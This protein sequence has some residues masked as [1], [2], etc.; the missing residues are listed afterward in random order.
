MNSLNQSDIFER[1]IILPPGERLSWVAEACGRDTALRTQVESLLRAHDEARSFMESTASDLKAAKPASESGGIE[2][3]GDRIGRYKL[4]QKIGEGGCGVVYMAE[5]EESV[6]RRVAIKIIKPGMDTKAV[7]ARFSAEREAL[8]R[9]EHPNI[10][11]VYDAGATLSGRPYFVMEL[12]RGLRIT[13][14]CDQNNFSTEQR[15]GLFNKVCEAIHHAHQ[16][17]I[18]H[19]DIKPSNIL[20]TLYDGQPVPKVIDFGIA[21]AMHGRLTDATLFTAFEQFIGTPAYVSPEQA[22]MS[23][24]DIDHRSDI[25][26][27]GVLLY[28][29]LMGRTPFD[30]NELLRSGLDE[31]RRRIREQEP[32]RPSLRLRT[33]NDSDRTTVARRRGTDAPRL[34]VQLRG[35]LDW[36]V[37]RCLEKDRGRRYD[38][39]NG[40]AADILRHLHNEPVTARPPSTAY[41]FQK[42]FRRHRLAFGAGAG[43]AVA[44]VAGFTV[45]TSLYLQERATHDRARAAEVKALEEKDRAE[46]ATRKAEE[47]TRRAQIETERGARL[48]ALVA[49]TMKDMGLL[50]ALPNDRLNFR[51]VLD[52]AANLKMELADLPELE[53]GVDET[54]GGAFF[55]MGDHKRAEEL[56]LDALKLR[57]RVQGENSPAVAESLKYL[58]L[59]YSGQSR[60]LEAEARHREAL[61]VQIRIYGPQ[62]PE[63]AATLSTIGWVLAQQA[64]HHE[65]E[66]FL[67]RALVQQRAVSTVPG[68][69][70]ASTLTRLGS[71]LTQEG[72][73]KEAEGVLNEALTINRRVFGQSSI[74]A[75]SSINMLAVTIALDQRR[76]PEA[77]ALYREAFEIRERINNPNATPAVSTS[78]ASVGSA[79]TLGEIGAALSTARSEARASRPPS[80]LE[81]LLMQRESMA[82]VENALREAQRFAHTQY[83]KDSWEEAFYLALTVWV[84]LQERKFEEAETHARQCLAIRLKLRPDDWS[85]F[86]AKHLLGAAQ[87]GQKR[88]AEAETLLVEGY[89]GMKARRATMPDFHLP[90]IGESA[91]RIID[92]YTELKRPDKVA[93]WKSEFE[94]LDDES[95]RSLVF[96]QPIAG[97]SHAGTLTKRLE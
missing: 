35:D 81:A 97:A 90:R 27:L 95:K 96:K 37:M 88:F 62:H 83:A 39:A 61:E 21:K 29:L 50:I 55:R 60:W 17:G 67:Q 58:G 13:D 69:E 28:E 44:L 51:T 7:I 33:L 41:L 2:K 4:L 19:R 89:Q 77:I 92:F 73:V 10:A 1:A 66:Q 84:Q 65:A 20:V 79:A 16:K 72:R 49:S 47:E 34:T 46:R 68:V 11:R 3:P 25:Y 78:P 54:L 15:L 63:V 31:M 18:I 76:L 5:Q 6:R 12:V 53:A 59:V 52:R 86:H 87:A 9:M 30:S 26:S 48:A 8:A 85:V 57:R 43:I 24:L 75:A 93:E 40:L 45:S 36:I 32:P 42:L 82:E 64:K 74:Q 70:V 94:S 22:E 38:T 71:V 23:G 91:L 56:F 14:Y 80:P